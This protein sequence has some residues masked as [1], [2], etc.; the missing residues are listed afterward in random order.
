MPIYVPGFTFTISRDR[1]CR[2]ANFSR[3]GAKTDESA[4]ACS[5]VSVGE[6]TNSS[7]FELL[8]FQALISIVV[9]EGE[10]LIWCLPR[11]QGGLWK[12][13]ANNVPHRSPHFQHAPS[14]VAF[15]RDSLPQNVPELW[16]EEYPCAFMRRSPPHPEWL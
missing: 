7:P 1:N 3:D 9:N 12:S 6:R 11:W 13:I 4:L 15:H 10:Q 8:H 5:S 2:A 16:N 14:S